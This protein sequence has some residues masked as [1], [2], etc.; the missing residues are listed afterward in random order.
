MHSRFFLNLIA[1]LLLLLSLLLL[2]LGWS[3][4]GP[5]EEVASPAS[6]ALTIE[7]GAGLRPAGVPPTSLD[8]A[9]SVTAAIPLFP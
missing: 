3:T 4:T 1:I 2:L 7:S 8:R 9:S 5:R 6:D